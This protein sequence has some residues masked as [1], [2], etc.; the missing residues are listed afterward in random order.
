MKKGTGSIL[1]STRVVFG[2]HK[3]GYIFPLVLCVRGTPPTEGP[4]SFVAFLRGAVTAYNYFIVEGN[5]LTVTSATQGSLSLL[6][7]SGATLETGELTIDHW[8]PGFKVRPFV[9]VKE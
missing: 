2:R 1:N 8:V 4:P 6:G 5:N 9:R 3:A 7:V